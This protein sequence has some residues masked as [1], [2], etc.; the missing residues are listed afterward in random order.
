MAYTEE[1]SAPEGV[2][3]HVRLLQ[4]IIK[5]RMANGTGQLFFNA[6]VI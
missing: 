4:L 3:R 2:H 5:T 6:R 1:P